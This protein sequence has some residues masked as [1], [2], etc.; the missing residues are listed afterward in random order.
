M[1]TRTAARQSY[2]KLSLVHARHFFPRVFVGAA[3]DGRLRAAVESWI[4]RVCAI[5]FGV[6]YNAFGGLG[7]VK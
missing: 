2:E 4:R 6:L 1:S 7:R 5:L 3:S